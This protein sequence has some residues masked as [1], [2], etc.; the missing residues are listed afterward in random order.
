M[1]QQPIGLGALPL[2]VQAVSLV[3][4]PA[5]VALFYM[6]K[7]MGLVTSLAEAQA[8]TLS[9]LSYQHQSIT[10]QHAEMLDHTKAIVRLERQICHNTAKTDTDRKA[11]WE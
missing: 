9:E 10:Q 5:I 6:A 11:C 8:K 3:G 4:F 7:D 1:E 2:W